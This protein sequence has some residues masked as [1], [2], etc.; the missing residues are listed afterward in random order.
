MGDQTSGT[1]NFNNTNNHMKKNMMKNRTKRTNTTY[2]L[3]KEENSVFDYTNN[4]T[5]NGEISF[6]KTGSKQMV[7]SSSNFATTNR[8]DFHHTHRDDS[9]QSDPKDV[10]LATEQSKKKRPDKIRSL[11][12]TDQELAK[13]NS[14][15]EI[16]SSNTEIVR[17][18]SETE[19]ISPLCPRV[20]GMVI[21]NFGFDLSDLSLIKKQSS[22]RN[23]DECLSI[24]NECF[25]FNFFYGDRFC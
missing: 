13:Q 11:T 10:Q 22:G 20:D 25:F 14:P 23:P 5:D 19:M 12:Q 16:S 21:E 2:N 15:Q 9:F 4:E 8:D 17:K 6:N 24:V 7:P 18:I 3:S 1:Q